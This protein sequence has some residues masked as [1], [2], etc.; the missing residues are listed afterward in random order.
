MKSGADGNRCPRLFHLRK[1]LRQRQRAGDDK[2]IGALAGDGFDG[3]ESGRRAQGEF[4][5]IDAAIGQ[6]LRERD[7]GLDIGNRDDR[8]HTASPDTLSI[9]LHQ[10][11]PIH[12]FEAGHRHRPFHHPA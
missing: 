8:H 5:D 2:H 1:M 9:T 7:G 3:L 6:S 10:S 11:N 4:D 12:T